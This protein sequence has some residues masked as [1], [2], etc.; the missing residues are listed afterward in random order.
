MTT[1]KYKELLKQANIPL[2]YQDD[3]TMYFQRYF[4]NPPKESTIK[5]D[6][7]IKEKINKKWS[8]QEIK[9]KINEPDLNWKNFL[10][11]K[12]KIKY[13]WD[14]KY[15]FIEYYSL[16]SYGWDAA[17]E[18][19]KSSNMWGG[20]VIHL[21]TAKEVGANII[22]TTDNFFLKQGEEFL[23]R[24]RLWGKLRI[25]PPEKMTENLTE[26]GFKL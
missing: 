7:F 4:N 15:Q 20:D 17:A 21:A 6:E 13:Y 23:K 24:K 16:S 25:C 1:D 11:I 3:I 14:N 22:I 19:C 9:R 5:E 18:M 2:K 12:R 26:M 8:F 10:E